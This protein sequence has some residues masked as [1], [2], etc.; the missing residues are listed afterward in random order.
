MENYYKLTKLFISYLL[1][2]KPSFDRTQK[3]QYDRSDSLL[4]GSLRTVVI[5]Q[6]TM[7]VFLQLAKGNTAKNVETCGILAG[8]L[9][10]N[11]LLITHI[12][13]PQQQG[14]SDSC[15]TM[16][17]EEIFDVQD[18][19]NLITLGWIHVSNLN[20]KEKT[21]LIRYICL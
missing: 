21:F 14:T 3:P 9:S 10:Q 6:N 20:K 18:Q 17:E 4:A 12:I 8:N 16:H 7:E 5:P 19:M 15:N 11:R 1:P 2:D 13:L